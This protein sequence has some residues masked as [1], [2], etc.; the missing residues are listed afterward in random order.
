MT[1]YC[2]KMHSKYRGIGFEV[3]IVWLGNHFMTLTTSIW[4]ETFILISTQFFLTF[5]WIFG[6]FQNF[7]TDKINLL[8]FFP[9]ILIFQFFLDVC[10]TCGNPAVCH[11]RTALYLYWKLN[12]QQH[13][14]FMLEW[15]SGWLKFHGLS[16]TA[17]IKVHVSYGVCIA[18]I[19]EKIDHVITEP[20]SI[21]I[22]ISD[23]IPSSPSCLVFLSQPSSQSC[24]GRARANRT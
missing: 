23:P 5:S 15:V 6:K 20:S 13:V 9:D 21:I 2:T 19:L 17:D 22:N 11:D 12:T 18:S 24:L 7:M 4:N 3:S 8:T 1:R 16:R 10:L 14:I